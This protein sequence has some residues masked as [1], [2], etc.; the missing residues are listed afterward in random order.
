MISIIFYLTIC[1]FISHVLFP[2]KQSNNLGELRRNVLA[3]DTNAYASNV[4][5][6]GV[7]PMKFSS[8]VFWLLI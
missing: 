6:S 3:A 2:L 8:Y 5:V 1:G 7:G 4:L